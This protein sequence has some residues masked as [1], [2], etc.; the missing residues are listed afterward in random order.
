MATSFL[1]SLVLANRFYGRL[2]VAAGGLLLPLVYLGG[3]A[4]WIV[5]FTFPTAAAVSIVQQVTQRGLSNTAWNAFYNVVPVARRA[6]V[7]AFMDGVPSQLGV[8]AAGLLALTAGRFLAPELVPWIGLVIA[9]LCTVVVVSV[10]RRYV[11]AL[12]QTLRS[13]VGEQVLE[14]APGLDLR[15]MTPD[16]RAALI[17]A[18]DVP[19]AAGRSFAASLLAQARDP[20]ARAAILRLLDDPDP[21]VRALAIEAALGGQAVEAATR[22]E[23]ERALDALLH[24][25]A[26]ERAAA[27]S[28][29]RLIGRH[30]PWDTL[31]PLTRDTDPIVRAE[32]IRS[33]GSLEP[34][35]DAPANDRLL[36]ALADPG[37][38]VRRAAA[39]SMAARPYVDRRVLERLDDPSADVRLAAISALD[40]HGPAVRAEATAW[41][42]RQVER[43]LHLAAMRDSVARD[44]PVPGP[45]T[46]LRAFLADVLDRRVAQ[47]RELCLASVAVLGEPAARDVIRRGLAA[48]DLDTRAQAIEAL[49][50]VGDRRLGSA[51]VRL[52]EGAP[53]ASHQDPRAALDR[54]RDDEDPWI[55][56]LARRIT[57]DGDGMATD[58]D[59]ASLD[60]MLRL[61]QVP[62]FSGLTPEDLQRVAAVAREAAFATG[63]TLIE[64]G[65]RGDELLVILDGQVLV[66]R[67]THDGGERSIR[68]YGAG[69]HIGE[70]AVLR[71]RPR[72][73]SVRA[74]GGP[75]RTLV[76][77]G[78]AL[79]AIL[80]ERPEAAMAMLATL[81]ERISVQ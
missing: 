14:G 45:D 1:V 18:L 62:L 12:V 74:D 59:L 70:L 72:A 50:S 23:A 2:G 27:L 49:D 75:V 19:D 56:G 73:A 21:S 52:V 38:R 55:R 36:A 5:R 44:R 71:D 24:G 60:T 63:A 32:A 42:E 11:D 61:R 46:E 41:A 66:T 51:I 15:V 13:G 48:R 80:L 47:Q 35:D 22:A 34:L 25:G 65:A 20:A 7:L 30:L 39:M 76:L 81:A 37:P 16:V 28:T 29:L 26:R 43:A 6:Q 33:T 64:E 53:G 78:E 58:D 3:F 57:A 4:V 67:R 17:R 8:I 10:R 68:T 40:G 9:A 31:E 54:L 77:D 79:R 69:D